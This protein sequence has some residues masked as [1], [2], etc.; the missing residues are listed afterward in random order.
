MSICPTH[1]HKKVRGRRLDVTRHKH[2]V[3]P[4]RR[5]R[6]LT[7]VW[8]SPTGVPYNTRGFYATVSTRS[9]RV[10]QTARFDRYGVVVFSKIHAPTTCSY[11]V[12]VYCKNGELF[13]QVIVPARNQTF[14][15][16]P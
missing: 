5:L 15:I 4:I 6:H 13:R 16:V 7:I 14:V 10:I 1:T 9:G 3:R 8:T 12:R 2:L 11:I